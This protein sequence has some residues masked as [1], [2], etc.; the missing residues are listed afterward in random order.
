M[1]RPLSMD[2]RER[3]MA[4]LDA[5]ETV[6][7][8]AEAH[9]GAEGALLPILVA[10]ADARTLTVCQLG[11]AAW[12]AQFLV[13]AHDRVRDPSR[14]SADLVRLPLVVWLAGVH[15]IA[16]PAFSVRHLRELRKTHQ[17]VVDSL[18]ALGQNEGDA[19]R[20]RDVVVLSTPSHTAAVH[21]GLVLALHG[22]PS[23]RRWHVLTMST[24][25]LTINAVDERTLIV[26]PTGAP[27]LVSPVENFFHPQRARIEAG[28]RFES[29]PFEVEVLK[30]D[31][32]PEGEHPVAI[33]S[34]R[35]HFAEPIAPGAPLFLATD[36][37]SGR[38]HRVDMP[39]PPGFLRVPRPLPELEDED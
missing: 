30:K 5:G 21:G 18:I 12:L 26:L 9:A 16:D 29:G 17:P 34:L 23:P 14:S 10:P 37:E 20:G 2:I 15:L 35:L 8:I 27:L 31:E 33:K 28:A 22:L 39:A 3:A 38:L 6:R 4:R 13:G 25:A 1:T 36:G 19:L 32:T 24:S 11:A 7:A